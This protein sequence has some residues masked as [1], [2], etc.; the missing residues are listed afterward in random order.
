MAKP[1]PGQPAGR[2]GL[3]HFIVVLV[4]PTIALFI[5]F[6]TCSLTIVLS[7]DFLVDFVSKLFANKTELLWFNNDANT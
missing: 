6:S 1:W 2:S 4:V 3:K 5:Y 7:F